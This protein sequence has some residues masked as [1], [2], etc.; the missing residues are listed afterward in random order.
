MNLTPITSPC[1]RDMG[2]GLKIWNFKQIFDV[3]VPLIDFETPRIFSIVVSTDA[4]QSRLSNR[5]D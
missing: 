1:L 3:S 2:S 5:P 4:L